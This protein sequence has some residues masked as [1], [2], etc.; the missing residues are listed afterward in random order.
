MEYAEC[1]SPGEKL[2]IGIEFDEMLTRIKQMKSLKN[3]IG[4]A[5]LDKTNH[6]DDV[7]AFLESSRADATVKKAIFQQFE[8]AKHLRDDDSGYQSFRSWLSWVKM[9]PA[10]TENPASLTLAA[11]PTTPVQ[12]YM[13]KCVS[14]MDEQLY[15]LKGVKVMVLAILFQRYV[16]R[17]ERSRPIGFIGDPGVGK[18]ML[19]TIIAKCENRHLER[20]SFQEKN[21]LDGS[22]MVWA[23][24]SPGQLYKAICR[25]KSSDPCILVDEIDK[26][27]AN[28]DGVTQVFLSALDPDHNHSFIDNYIQYFP[29]N[30]SQVCFILT[31]NT[32]N[33]H[34]ALHDRINW[35]HVPSYNRQ[36]RV[37]ILQNYILPKVCARA[38]HKLTITDAAVELLLQHP[39]MGSVRKIEGVIDALCMR[40]SLQA[41]TT[42]IVNSTEDAHVVSNNDI[43]AYF[44]SSGNGSAHHMAMFG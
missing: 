34:P 42:G 20:V 10:H 37:D 22:N 12:E 44:E 8:L 18:T 15:G 33:L 5:F 17:N 25:S 40:K 24:S 32:A 21:A 1:D 9:L 29:I 7:I 3:N 14:I 30:L 23:G 35:I 41:N 36:E 16:N 11:L 19:A 4:C 26:I 13:N 6:N 39:G 31:A 27:P 38:N 43:A 28:E 2:I